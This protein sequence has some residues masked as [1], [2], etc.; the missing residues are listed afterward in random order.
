MSD[1][2]CIAFSVT[3]RDRFGDFGLVNV[4]ILRKLEN[5]LEIDTFLMS[6]RVLQRGIEQYAMNKIFEIARSGNFDYIKG[7]YIPTNKNVMVKNFFDQYGF[8]LLTGGDDGEDL[9]W[10]LPVSKYTC[11]EVFV[12]EISD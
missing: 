7:R 10:G 4:V 11:R 3:V 12:E 9:V 6:C 8:E 2:K 1:D 5:C